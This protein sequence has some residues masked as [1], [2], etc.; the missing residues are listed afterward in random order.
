MTSDIKT[1]FDQIKANKKTLENELHSKNRQIRKIKKEIINHQKARQVITEILEQTQTQIKIK[2][3]SLVTL[4]IQ[5]IFQDDFTFCLN[6]QQKR[7]NVEATPIV[8][9]KDEEFNA[10]N[11]LGGAIIDVISFALRIVFWSLDNER[12]RP[13]FILDEPF[14]FAGKLIDKVGEFLKYINKELGIQIIFISHDNKLINF[15]DTIYQVEKKNKK[16]IVT[17]IK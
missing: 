2:I 14:R 1:I 9:I 15:C 10:K 8:K 12:T 7:N 4:A 5:S 3:E 17:K 6:F 11:D 13:V 16:S